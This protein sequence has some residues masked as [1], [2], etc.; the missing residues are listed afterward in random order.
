MV[1]SCSLGKML[2]GEH[3]GRGM[4]GREMAITDPQDQLIKN[5]RHNLKREYFQNY[6][7]N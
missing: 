3:E 7:M 5:Y 4:T 2:Q 1:V 6:L